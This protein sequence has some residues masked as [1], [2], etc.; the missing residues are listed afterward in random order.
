MLNSC[1]AGKDNIFDKIQK[2]RKVKNSA[3][4]SIDGNKDPEGRF[5]EVYGNLY[6]ST[7]DKDETEAIMSEITCSIN[8]D[9]LEDVNLVIPEVIEGVVK[10]QI[11]SNM[12]HL[13]SIITS[14]I[15]SKPS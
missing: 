2:M 8:I 11:V 12:H 3:P 13:R 10:I 7:N 9:S 14:R 15:S 5:A 6:N 1:I 4:N